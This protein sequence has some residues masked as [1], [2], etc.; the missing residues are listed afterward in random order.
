MFQRGGGAGPAS[1]WPAPPAARGEAPGPAP[2]GRCVEE[3]ARRL[4]E[5][6]PG[7][8]LQ[9]T[10]L[11][12]YSCGGSA[13]RGLGLALVAGYP[14]GVLRNDRSPPGGTPGPA[15]EEGRGRPLGGQEMSGCAL[16]VRGCP[17]KPSVCRLGPLRPG[18]GHRGGNAGSPVR[19]GAVFLACGAVVLSLLLVLSSARSVGGF[20]MSRWHG[21]GLG[22][23]L[24]MGAGGGSLVV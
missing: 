22:E 1:S 15:G 10:E 19:C 8:G 9:S 23:H 18:Y 4:S 7:R 21:A 14:R 5:G 11:R 24:E 16:K 20:A 13:V 6:F 12:G 17:F 2:V 3:P